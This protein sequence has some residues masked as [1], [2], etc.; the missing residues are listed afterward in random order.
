MSYFGELRSD[1]AVGWTV[2]WKVKIS[3][4]RTFSLL[5]LAIRDP[6]KEELRTE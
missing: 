1:G 2:E 6:D 4:S 5:L 3:S